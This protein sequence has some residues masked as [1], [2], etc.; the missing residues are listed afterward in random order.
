MGLLDDAKN[1]L[2]GLTGAAEQAVDAIGADK[3]T[4]A[5][6]AATDKVDDMTGGAAAPVTEK[7]DEA[8]TSAVEGMSNN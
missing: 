3:I 2:G 5:V 6:D 8:V 4:G 7:V 1:A